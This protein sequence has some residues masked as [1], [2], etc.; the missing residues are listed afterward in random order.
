MKYYSSWKELSNLDLHI[1]KQL[2]VLS[3]FS[4]NW[5]KIQIKTTILKLKSN[6]EFRKKWWFSLLQALFCLPNNESLTNRERSICI[7]QWSTKAWEFSFWKDLMMIR[8]ASA[9]TKVSKVVSIFTLFAHQN[10]SVITPASVLYPFMCASFYLV[11]N[12]WIILTIT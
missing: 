2:V 7:W 11:K 1:H 10:C 6:K 12:V 4:K 9:A 8:Q 5:K 3:N